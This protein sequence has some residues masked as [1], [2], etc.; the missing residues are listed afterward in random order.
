[1]VLKIFSPLARLGSRPEAS[2]LKLLMAKGWKGL[3]R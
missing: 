1:M 3:A 2:V